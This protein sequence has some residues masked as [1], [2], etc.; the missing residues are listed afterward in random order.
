MGSNCLLENIEKM[1]FITHL[2]LI[3]DMGGME[4]TDMACLVSSVIK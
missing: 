3:A 2:H 4:I 1:D